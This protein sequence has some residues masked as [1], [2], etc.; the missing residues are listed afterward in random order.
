M[1]APPRIA[2]LQNTLLQIFI[3]R[4]KGKQQLEQGNKKSKPRAIKSLNPM[5]YVPLKLFYFRDKWPS[6]SL[7]WPT[8]LK[9]ESWQGL[10]CRPQRCVLWVHRRRVPNRG[11]AL[12]WRDGPERVEHQIRSVG[13]DTP[14]LLF[15]AILEIGSG[16]LIFNWLPTFEKQGDFT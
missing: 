2:R 10:G 14:L 11:P 13:K 16:R 8:L 12:W 15:E 1:Q 9:E 5:Q 7:L 4:F 6:F 3:F